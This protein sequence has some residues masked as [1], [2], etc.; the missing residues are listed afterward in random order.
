MCKIQVKEMRNMKKTKFGI[1]MAVMALSQ[2]CSAVLVAEWNFNDSG[3]LGNDAAGAF[4]L[5]TGSGF[6]TPTYEAAGRSGGAARFVNDSSFV[7]P[8]D[9]YPN[10]SFS[11][12]V[13][14]KADDKSITSLITPYSRRAGFEIY[15]TGETWRSRVWKHDL[16]ADYKVGPAIVPDE[17]IHIALVYRKTS[18]PDASGNYTGTFR[19]WVNGVNIGGVNSAEYNAND[20]YTMSLGSYGTADFRGLMDEVKI[21]NHDLSPE[22]I[23]VLAAVPEPASVSLLG[24]VSVGLFLVRRSLFV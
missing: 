7:T 4:D 3:D 2:M 1:A 20:T 9:I 10:G 6:S 21:Y 5:S 13:W 19:M 17:W 12:S 8:V 24:M 18:G 15:E 16:T 23:A 22:E 11:L 14:A